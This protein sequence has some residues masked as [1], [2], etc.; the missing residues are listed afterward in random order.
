MRSV[1]FVCQCHYFCLLVGLM[2][3]SSA[4]F[5]ETCD[6]WKEIINACWWC[7][8]VTDTDSGS[9]PLSSPLPR[10]FRTCINASHTVTDR[11]SRH[12]AKWMTSTNELIHNISAAICMADVQIRIRINREIQFESRITSDCSWTLWGGRLSLSEYSLVHHHRH[13][14]HHHHHHQY[15]LS[16]V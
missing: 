5:I 12:S 2:H 8:P 10:Y 13:H 11:F 7:D 14:H 9:L 3:K 15:R 6:Q 16:N 4:D 1:Q